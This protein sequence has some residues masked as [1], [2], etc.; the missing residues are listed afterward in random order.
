M[1]GEFKEVFSFRNLIEGVA[2]K[3]GTF[4]GRVSDKALGV[5]RSPFA[6]VKKDVFVVEVSVEEGFGGRR[7]DEFVAFGREVRVVVFEG[8]AVVSWEVAH[9]LGELDEGLYG[10]GFWLIDKAGSRAKAFH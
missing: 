9:F 2:E 5:D 3:G 1:D 10:L 8:E 6:L 4:V 7:F